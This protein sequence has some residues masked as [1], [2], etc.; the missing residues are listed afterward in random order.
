[1]DLLD[2]IG[3]GNIHRCRQIEPCEATIY[4]MEGDKL[5]SFSAIGKAE[6][7]L[8]M[9]AQQKK[10]PPLELPVS[11]SKESSVKVS[12]QLLFDIMA[13]IENLY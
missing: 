6:L 9:E 11:F 1:M 8:D 10:F 7:T 3:S 12:V 5:K 2:V 4:S 13:I